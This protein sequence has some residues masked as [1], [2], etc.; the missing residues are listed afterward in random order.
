LRIR[1][2]ALAELTGGQS[3][4]RGRKERTAITIDFFRIHFPGSLLMF[5]PMS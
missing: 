2:A 4:G 5:T 3:H 1:C